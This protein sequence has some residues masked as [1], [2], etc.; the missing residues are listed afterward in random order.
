M[1]KSSKDHLTLIPYPG[2]IFV[3]I[4]NDFI[5]H[6]KGWNK[7]QKNLEKLDFFVYLDHFSAKKNILFFEN[8]T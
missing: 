8:L 5:F 3:K 1:S 4:E 7:C 2:A 6:F